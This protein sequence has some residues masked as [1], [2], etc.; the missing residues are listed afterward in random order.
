VNK[1]INA[2]VAIMR[3]IEHYMIGEV[4]NM[5]RKIHVINITSVKDAKEKKRRIIKNM[6]GVPGTT[7]QITRVNSL[8]FVKDAK[9]KKKNIIKNMNG[10]I[11]VI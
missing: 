4:L 9:K 1:Y 8:A 10:E 7:S 6:N 2:N 11:G 3:K 5:L